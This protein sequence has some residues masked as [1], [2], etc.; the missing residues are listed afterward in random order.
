[1]N[2]SLKTN[3]DKLRQMVDHHHDNA[4][5]AIADRDIKLLQICGLK[6]ELLQA[7][8]A[9][10]ERRSTCLS[11][12]GE[13]A[14]LSTKLSEMESVLANATEDV[15]ALTNKNAYLEDELKNAT[16]VR[17]ESNC[18]V[19]LLS[20][21][22]ALQQ[23]ENQIEILREEIDCF[24]TQLDQ[25]NQ[26]ITDLRQTISY[27]EANE[28]K[29][30]SVS[31]MSVENDHSVEYNGN[32]L[33]ENND[34]VILE[35]NDNDESIIETQLLQ[36][37]T[38]KHGPISTCVTLHDI[39]EESKLTVQSLSLSFADTPMPVIPA[40]IMKVIIDKCNWKKFVN[41]IWRTQ[42][43]YMKASWKEL[44]DEWN[45]PGCPETFT[46]EHM[47][48]IVG[49]SKEPFARHVVSTVPLL[50]QDAVLVQ[51]G[52]HG[53]ELEHMQSRYLR[54]HKPWADKQQNPY[55]AI[56]S[57]Y[58]FTL[59]HLAPH[60]A[61]QVKGM[62]FIAN[63]EREVNEDGTTNR[64]INTGHDSDQLHY[65]FVLYW[66]EVIS[67][68]KQLDP[69]S[70]YLDPAVIYL[71]RKK[72]FEYEVGFQNLP[73]YNRSTGEIE[74]IQDETEVTLALAAGNEAIQH[75]LQTLT[76]RCAELVIIG[77]TWNV[78][79]D[80]TDS[81]SLLTNISFVE[82]ELNT[83]THFG[84]LAISGI[85]INHRRQESPG[86]FVLGDRSGNGVK[87]LKGLINEKL[88]LYKYINSQIVDARSA[89]KGPVNNAA[90]IYRKRLHMYILNAF[91]GSTNNEQRWRM[92]VKFPDGGY[93]EMSIV[94]SINAI[95]DL[96]R[97]QLWRID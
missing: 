70:M 22:H 9:I 89:T 60:K 71:R 92:L 55:K 72:D 53:L 56:M 6:E 3:I 16:T 49:M 97:K 85:V 95:Q 91:Y 74:A 20:V 29:S 13:I 78:S 33:F 48:E 41:K 51:H 50:S 87:R 11:Y 43:D 45:Y 61:N 54:L 52:N 25:K 2:A 44:K 82:N 1:M 76:E 10:E 79:A 32:V 69:E 64:W 58:H 7:N 63:F 96:V 14:T 17:E 77:K 4:E 73:N 62:M 47:I 12:E 5:Q 83:C 31:D 21:Q 40:K 27:Y 90:L 57:I 24:R 42:R 18:R 46:D 19:H 65:A 35:T 81:N 66:N 8:V 59:V 38:K 88:E 94:D 34:D 93:I 36:A 39:P 26:F 84:Q 15:A 67:W 30:L 75:S 28:D 37:T 23:S 80:T 68:Y 86:D